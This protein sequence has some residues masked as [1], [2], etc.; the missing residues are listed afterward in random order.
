MNFKEL[1]FK[2]LIKIGNLIFSKYHF[3]YHHLDWWGNS[4][5]TDYLKSY[6]NFKSSN[7]DRRWMLAQL[8]RLVRNVPGDTVE[9]G[10]YRG[11]SSSVICEE[12][13]SSSFS[14]KH[15]IF[16]SFEGLS[17]PDA[18]DGNHWTQGDLFCGL[19]EVKR[20]LSQYKNVNYYQGW[21]PDRF[22][23]VS[24]ERFS[25]VHIDVD[26]FQ[27]TLDSLAFFYER[28]Q[29]GGIIICDDYGISNCPGATS[30]VDG[31]LLDKKEKMLPLC[32]GGGFMIKGN[33]TGE[34][35]YQ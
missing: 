32:C 11:A 20:N 8:A 31:F 1:R 9:C 19:A 7:D 33:A 5:F 24:R 25:L 6:G 29:Q 3:K 27:P 14:K 16:D 34:C 28:M 30:A 26:L 21:I 22:P 12:N 4:R 10:V 13:E 18:Q 2:A 35:L 15:H 23:E 17:E